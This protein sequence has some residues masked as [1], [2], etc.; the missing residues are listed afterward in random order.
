MGHYTFSDVLKFNPYHD[1]RGRFASANSATSFTIRTKDPSKQGLADRAKEREKERDAAEAPKETPRIQAI[2]NA[3]DQIRHQNYETAVV[4]DKDGNEVMKKDGGQNSVGFSPM[5]C[6]MLRNNTLTHNHPRSSM[7]S[8]EDTLCFV[9]NELEEIRATNREGVTYSIKRGEGYSK[10]KGMAFV[11]EYDGRYKKAINYAQNDLDSRGFREKIMSGEI[12]QAQANK[13]FTRVV[14]NRMVQWTTSHASEY[15]VDF[16]VEKRTV[17]KSCDTGG[18]TIGKAEEDAEFL[19]DGETARLEDEAFQEW[20]DNPKEVAKTFDEVLKFNP[21]HDA[22]GRFSTA[23]GYASFTHA[24]GK[25]KAHDLAIQ[26]EKERMAGIMPSAAQ[27]KTLR[28]IE[29]RTRNLKKEQFRVVDRNGEVVMQKQ[30]DK[31]SVSYSIGEARDNFPGNI[32]IHN[33]PDG[34]TFST[35]DLSD[36]GHGATEIRAAAP[37]GTYI[38]RDINHGTKWNAN[39][40]G[41]YEMRDD[42]DAASATF[43]TDRQLRSQIRKPFDE[44]LKPMVD[45]WD[46]RRSEGASQEELTSLA[47]EYTQACDAM[48]PQI[49]KAVRTAYVQ[50]YHDWYK[51]NASTYGMEYEF[52]PAKTRTKKNYSDDFGSI[53]KGTGEIVLDRQLQ[54]DIEEMTETI[55]QDLKSSLQKDT[56][57]S[58]SIFKTSD[59]KRLVFGWASVS[60]D[61]DG[62]QLEDRQHDMI[63]PEDLEAAAYE[64]VLNFRDAGEEHIP[65]L[66]KKARLVESCVFTEEKQ[67]A[68]GIPPGILPVAWWIGFYVDDDEAWAKIKNGTYRMFSI[69][70]KAKRVPVEKSAPPEQEDPDRFDHIKEFP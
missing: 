68:M 38:L 8:M 52:I 58:F 12:T 51:S 7:F 60:I 50:Q 66:R 14:A 27:E 17:T 48:R 5:E 31:N 9:K 57:K 69:E 36:I 64:Y 25:S 54:E 16:T 28:G 11:T 44:Q 41:W 40:K 24:P 43:K 70:G 10:G 61:V 4:I 20:L 19:L 35:A 21:Y 65:S 33:H 62:E 23:N 6:F 63:D 32:T 46:K 55:M 47:N 34:G 39:Q 56:E 37:E 42:L 13:E 59:D 45:K 15:G 67:Q 1:S 18:F 22:R 29:N 3:E 2:H 53:E 49:E 26:R 30:G